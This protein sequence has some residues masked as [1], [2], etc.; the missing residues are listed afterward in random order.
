MTRIGIIGEFDG[1]F[2]THVA[3]NAAI[4]HSRAG[5]QADVA[6][7]WVST[8]RLDEALFE[9]C[10]GVWVAPGSPYKDMQKT[11]RTIQFARERRV[12]TLGTCG[13]FQHMMIEYARNVLGITDAQHAEYDPYGSCLFISELACSL[14]GREMDLRLVAGSK[15]AEI[16]GATKVTEQYYCN[17]AVNPEY[18]DQIRSGPLQ[19]CGSD[20]EG[21]VRVIEHPDHPF[22]VGT[23]FVPQ[24]LSTADRPHPLIRAFVSAAIDYDR[25]RAAD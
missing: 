2:E 23:L 19:V 17:F 6:Y 24:A 13:G 15:V 4:E 7:E 3:T 10:S 21:E 20:S 16:Y 18:V 5:L 11:L 25:H 22:Y 9:R 12:P 8:G 14:A 1:A